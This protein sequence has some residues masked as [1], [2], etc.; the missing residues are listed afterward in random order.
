MDIFRRHAGVTSNNYGREKPSIPELPKT[1]EELEGLWHRGFR[2]L[3]ESSP[4]DER[5]GGKYHPGGV[6]VTTIER[7]CPFCSMR[8]QAVRKSGCFMH[9]IHPDSCPNCSYPNNILNALLQHKK[10]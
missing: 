8:F 7:E 1:T 6:A 2:D 10:H 4:V 3:W 5:T 9:Y